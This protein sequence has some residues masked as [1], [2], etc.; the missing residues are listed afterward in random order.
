MERGGRDG[1]E[2]AEEMDRDGGEQA[3]G[4]D[5]ST[6]HRPGSGLRLCRTGV[7]WRRAWMCL[8]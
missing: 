3:E 8:G 4:M 2:Q 6:D 5:P 7:A 1:G